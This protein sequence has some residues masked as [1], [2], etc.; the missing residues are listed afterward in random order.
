MTL[1]GAQG[2]LLKENGMARYRV[3]SAAV[4]ALG[5]RSKLEVIVNQQLVDAGI[6]FS[7]EGQLNK[8][9][10]VKPETKHTYLADFLLSNCILIEAKGRFTVEDRKK[11]LYIQEQHPILDI[12]FLFSNAQNKLRKGSPTTYATWC[13]KKNFMW[14]DKVIPQEWLEEEKDAVEKAQ[15]IEILKE[16]NNVK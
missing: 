11:H 12:R 15:I 1:E 14:A 16:M 2:V 6:R 4:K 8:I 7:Y 3:P 9:K 5:F 10:Y 13:D